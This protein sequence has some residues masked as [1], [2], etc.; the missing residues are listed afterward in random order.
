M[1][2]LGTMVFKQLF[3]KHKYKQLGELP[4]SF[5]YDDGYKASVPITFLE[6]S[7]CGKRKLIRSEKWYYNDN[8]LSK[9]FLWEKGQ[10]DMTFD[11]E[12]CYIE[13]E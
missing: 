13:G 9:V 2:I 10:L 11:D 6:C 7:E 5:V 8:L 4:C 12:T 1:R 3:C